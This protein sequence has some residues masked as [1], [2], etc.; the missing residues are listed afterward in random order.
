MISYATQCYQ[1]NNKKLCNSNTF[2]PMEIQWKFNGNPNHGR[3]EFPVKG[4]PH[5]FAQPTIYRWKNADDDFDN[6][7]DFDDFD[8][9]NDYY[10][11]YVQDSK[12]FGPSQKV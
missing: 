7:A 5:T 9:Y 1:N 8:Y 12:I 3:T 2:Y 10:Y 4:R 11:D 6:F